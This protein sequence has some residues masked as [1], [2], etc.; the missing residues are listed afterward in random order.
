MDKIKDLTVDVYLK[1]MAVCDFP[2]P[3]AG[4][5]AATAAAMAA[6]LLEM[7][8]DG[9]LRKHGENALLKESLA[10]GERLRTACLDLADEDIIAYSRV[11]AAAKDKKAD[12]Q[13]YQEAMKGATE[14][15]L[16]ILSHCHTLLVQIEK[17]IGS[18]FSRVLGDLV[19]G[20]YLAEAAAA[21]SKSGVEVNL[22]LITDPGFKEK[23]LPAARALYQACLDL[24][25]DI[26]GEVFPQTTGKNSS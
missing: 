19:G 10:V 14:P 4:S 9:S 17:I 12:P 7:S 3:A 23:H 24:K 20:V 15:F 8:C 11:I 5:A 16:T 13:A 18:S 1:K 26:L 22:A 21:A 2:S 25:N 6:A